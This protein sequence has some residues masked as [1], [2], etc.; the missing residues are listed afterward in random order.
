MRDKHQHHGEGISKITLLFCLPLVLVWGCGPLPPDERVIAD[1]R[2]GPVATAVPVQ[3]PQPVATSAPPG[4]APPLLPPPSPVPVPTPAMPETPS[5]TP[6]PMAEAT[7][8]PTAIPDPAPTATVQV[9]PKIERIVF[10]VDEPDTQHSVVR[11]GNQED[12]FQHRPEYE[13]LVGMDPV[14][15]ALVPELA[16]EWEVLDSGRTFR[17]QLRNGVPFHGGWGDFTAQDVVHTHEQLVREDSRDS[18]ASSWRRD[19][20][21]VEAMSAYVVEFRLNQPMPGFLNAVGERQGLLP[22]QSAAHFQTFGE[23]TDVASLFIAGTG[24][25]QMLERSAGSGILFE[26]PPE[27]HWRVTPDFREFEFRFQSDPSV[28]LAALLTGD[29]H[30]AELPVAQE[31]DALSAGMQVSRGSAPTHG[32]WVNISCCWEDPETGAYPARPESPLT[33][34]TVR[35]ALSKTIDR[36]LINDAY[37]DGKGAT[38]YLNH[39]HPTRLGWNPAW[40]SDFQDQYGYDPAAARALLAQAGYDQANRLETAIEGMDLPHFPIA[41]F[42][43]EAVAGFFSDVGV[44]VNLVWRDPDHRMEQQR[45]MEDDNLLTIAASSGDQYRGFPQW[46]TPIFDESNANNVPALTE[47]TRR[48]LGTFDIEQQS[49]LWRELGDMSYANYLTLPLFWFHA[50]VTYNPEVVSEYPFPGG[51]PGA[52]TH[53]HT[54]KAVNSP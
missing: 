53:V 2:V 11:H 22:I 23:P 33:N 7:P 48:I 41:D 39:W 38:M 25:Y 17:F 40:E 18:R 9:A 19:V 35:K 3:S 5:P 10:S 47:L 14:A 36:Q 6:T 31:G 29:V 15:G 45:N 37:F 24:P 52:W 1:D 32:A 28:R 43:G 13:H 34:V 44:R 16:T 42:I 4:E 49:Q 20:V 30:I 50:D 54:I 12:S 27:T 21:R 26:R 8:E 51:I 46:T